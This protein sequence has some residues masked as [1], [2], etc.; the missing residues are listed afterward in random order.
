MST[1]VGKTVGK[2]RILE[3]IGSSG[4]ATVYRAYDPSL[5]REVALKVLHAYFAQERELVQRFLDEMG[6]IARLRHPNIVPVYE[7]GEDDGRVWI[8]MEYIPGGSLK[9]RL[10]GPLDLKISAKI[11]AGVAAALDYA[12]EHGIMHR[13]IKLSNVFVPSEGRVLLSDFG[14]ATLGEGMHPLMKTGLTTPM[15]EYMSPEQAE[16]HK[17]DRR[18][19]VYALGVLLFELLTHEVP[20]FGDSA[21][22]I[23]A[24]QTI[25]LPTMPSALNPG[26]PEAVDGVIARALAGRPD[27]RH[28]TAGEMAQ[29]LDAAV[30]GEETRVSFEEALEEAGRVAPAWPETP[31]PGWTVCP[32]CGRTNRPN[33]QFCSR[34]GAKLPVLIPIIEHLSWVERIA[35][36]SPRKKALAALLSISVL[37]LIGGGAA[38]AASRPVELPPPSSNVSSYV[39]DEWAM[40]GHNPAHT[41]FVEVADT[42]PQGRLRWRFV[43]GAPIRSSVA[44]VGGKVYLATGERRIVALDAQDGELLWEVGVTGPV[45][46]SPAVAGGIVYVGLYD[47]RLLALDAESGELR[48]EYQ[49]GN[50]IYG[51]PAVVD[52]VV[53]VGSGDNSVHALD[54][55]T[56]A[57]RWKF[58]T[59][60]WVSS[61]P[62]VSGGLVC[63]GS[64]GWM[65]YVIDAK[66]GQEVLTFRFLAPLDSSPAIGGNIAYMG[67]D[68]RSMRA[69]DMRPPMSQARRWM[70][71]KSLWL[72][73]NLHLQGIAPTPPTQVGLVWLVN[74]RGP[75]T[76]VPAVAD[77]TVYFGSQ[78]GRLYALEAAT[79]KQRWQ[80]KAG[81]AIGSSPAAVGGTLYFGSDDGRLNAVD[82]ESGEKLWEFATGG[83]IMASPAVVKG[84]VYIGS[85]DGVLYAIE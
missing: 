43:T 21:E 77:D 32:E 62:A 39:A 40:W 60:G 71:E 83:K 67:G 58:R 28:T 5:N 57:F 38:Y 49:S 18:S 42:Q 12:H 37:F 68:D 6:T 19:D 65:F 79:G 33:R 76:T 25:Y 66:N 3:N 48:W 17:L 41:N 50:P 22:T 13:N 27:G 44:V 80:F 45:D 20:Y 56:G 69:I 59:N 11:I 53:Y 36:W 85:T 24:K 10:K 14:M 2:Y 61:S 82:R 46:S 54:A 1:E 30:A 78:D 34:C 23:W 9:D 52:G 4:I 81:G 74:A 55:M 29:R 73:T 7:Y 70:I 35:R 72:W 15:P 84:V 8:A 16:G 64:R 26:I 47:G 31:P 51:S 63:V 75:I